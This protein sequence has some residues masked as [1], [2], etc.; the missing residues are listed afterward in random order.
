MWPVFLLRI[1][2]L[3]GQQKQ[4]CEDQML[5]FLPGIRKQAFYFLKGAFQALFRVFSYWATLSTALTLEA[6]MI[7]HCWVVDGSWLCKAEYFSS[8]GSEGN[9]KETTWLQHRVIHRQLEGPGEETGSLFLAKQ[10]SEVH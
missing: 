4:K 7:R 1:K 9:Q 5:Y 3:G 10:L 8:W 6:F 2:K